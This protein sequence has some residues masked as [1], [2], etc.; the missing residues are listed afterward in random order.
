MLYANFVLIKFGD[1]LALKGKFKSNDT[2]F[3]AWYCLCYIDV[4]LT[5][6]EG[7]CWCDVVNET[8]NETLN[9]SA[10]LRL[11]LLKEFGAGFLLRSSWIHLT[12]CG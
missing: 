10:K 9:R 7:D 6:L 4:S 3:Y 5:V 12:N 8:K 2:F 1:I 11:D